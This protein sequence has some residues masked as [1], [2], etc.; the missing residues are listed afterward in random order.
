MFEISKETNEIFKAL[1][2]VQNEFL[3]IF[4][5]SQGKQNKYADYAQII[6]K[7]KPILTDAGI[8]LIQ[9]VTYVEN[10]NGDTQ[11]SITTMLIH[12]DS[13]QYIKSTSLCFEM[14]DRKNKSGDSILSQEQR[15]G[16]GIT[17]M[18]RY[19]LSCM[20][21]WA[22]GDYDLDQGV[23]DS[24]KPQRPEV[25][26]DKKQTWDNAKKAYIRDGNFDKILEKADISE[27]NQLKII[28]E[29]QED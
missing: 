21:S 25:T 23:L 4:K 11:A 1:L 3:V 17:Y 5:A 12:A 24:M 10:Q 2:S 20:L 14:T 28:Q 16:G 27:E 29:A 13:G 7:C 18:K 22:T 19:A 9:P 6:G 8:L 15:I 26:P